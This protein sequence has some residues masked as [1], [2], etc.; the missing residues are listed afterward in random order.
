MLSLVLLAGTALVVVQMG[1]FS[2]SNYFKI[3]DDSYYDSV[4]SELENHAV[5]YTLP[6]GIDSSVVDDVFLYHEVQRDVDG[7][8]T[9]AFN[10]F[11]YTPDMS[12]IE[13]RLSE[14]VTAFF[15]SNGVTVDEQT[16]EI[17]EKYIEEIKE[18][19]VSEV[20]MPM[21]DLLMRARSTFTKVFTVAMVAVCV[22]A[23]ILGVLCVKLH[24]WAHRG[25]R[26]IAYAFGGT[27]VMSFAAPFALYISRFYERIQLAPD[28]FYRFGV[29]FIKNI[30]SLCMFAALVWL[31]FTLIM[32][33][34]IAIMRRQKKSHRSNS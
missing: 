13:T 20:K 6:T 34:I 3:L 22:L 7:Y 31:L 27:S 1:C 30:L 8:I 33:F 18:V 19:Y 9:G 10:R 2:Q 15:N 29:A 17:I 21:I 16:S 26:Y 28:Y 24:R 11:E 5:D 4:L 14:N 23:L 32:I 12:G 25:L